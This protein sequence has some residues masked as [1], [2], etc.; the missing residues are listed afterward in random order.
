[1]ENKPTDSSNMQTDPGSPPSDMDRIGGSHNKETIS[2]ILNDNASP[3]VRTSQK[4]LLPFSPGRERK[5]KCLQDENANV[6]APGYHPTSGKNILLADK[7]YEK[8]VISKESISRPK[9]LRPSRNIN[10]AA[11]FTHSGQEDKLSSRPKSK[12]NAGR[13]SM[14]STSRRIASTR[15]LNNSVSKVDSQPMFASD[16]YRQL[17]LEKAQK[18]QLEKQRAHFVKPVGE[19]PLLSLQIV[20]SQYFRSHLL[21]LLCGRPYPLPSFS[22][23]KNE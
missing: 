7:M 16:V 17:A 12:S 21:D 13:N 10:K 22:I 11:E 20:E 14:M 15:G 2:A 4:R 5:R 1:M 9:P 19:F 6:S 18:E 23:L 3:P 8:E